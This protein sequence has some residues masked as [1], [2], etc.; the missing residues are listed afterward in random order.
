M[1]RRKKK[2]KEDGAPSHPLGRP[3][4]PVSRKT[5]FPK[6][7]AMSCFQEVH[8]RLCKGWPLKKVAEYIQHDCEEYTDAS[9]HT[10][11]KQLQNYRAS[12]PPAER[13]KYTMSKSH[14]DAIDEVEEDIDEV[15]ELIKLYRRQEKRLSIDEKVEQNIGKLMPTMTQEVRATAELLRTIATIKMDL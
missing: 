14:M 9:H 2:T 10:V 3:M 12:I 13:A 15:K 8:E 4:R 6:L 7:R 1:S 11:V 5:T